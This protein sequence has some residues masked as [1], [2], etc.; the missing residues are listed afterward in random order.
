MVPNCERS[1]HRD[2]SVSIIALEWVQANIAAFGG[3]PGK[4]TLFGESAGGFS[5]MHHLVSPK[6]S[7]GLFHA[8]IPMSGNIH[9]SFL[10]AD[11]SR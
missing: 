8:A 6:G 2:I 5:T 7:R 1:C 11:R 10:N 3:D 9:S 4:V